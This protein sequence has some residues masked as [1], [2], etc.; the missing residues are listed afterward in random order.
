MITVSTRNL[1]E[2]IR[3]ADAFKLPDMSEG[4]GYLFDNLYMSLS[5]G[6]DATLS[7]LDFD[8]FEEDDLNSL[9]DLYTEVFEKNYYAADGVASTLREAL[10]VCKAAAYV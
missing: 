6:E 9:N 4:T 1:V 5:K 3:E 7:S 8:A 2:A 10:P